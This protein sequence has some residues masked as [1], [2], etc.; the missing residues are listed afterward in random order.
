MQHISALY[1]I[2]W[3]RAVA[4]AFTP[5]SGKIMYFFKIK[6]SYELNKSSHTQ[7]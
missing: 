1:F 4:G 3:S 5:F 2:N 6:I 7:P